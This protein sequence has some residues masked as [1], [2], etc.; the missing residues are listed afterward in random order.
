MVEIVARMMKPKNE[1]YGLI[2]A[3]IIIVTL[4]R[5]VG[6][7]LGVCSEALSGSVLLALCSGVILEMPREPYIVLG[8]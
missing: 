7:Y 8:I 1:N 4:G 5:R 6:A 3:T 2:F